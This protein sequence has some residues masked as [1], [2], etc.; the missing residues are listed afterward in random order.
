MEEF[1]VCWLMY[2]VA[3]CV[4]CSKRINSL[5]KWASEE[6]RVGEL[7]SQGQLEDAE[8]CSRSLVESLPSVESPYVLRCRHQMAV[9][10]EDNHKVAEAAEVMASVVAGRKHLLG[11]MQEDTI[12]STNFLAGQFRKLERYEE[13]E[14]LYRDVLKF[15]TLEAGDDDPRTLTALVRN[16]F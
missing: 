3:E 12:D 7:L 10:L 13:A 14:Q 15:R 6:E 16:H 8:A 5:S 4:K 9:I 1:L 11:D 2:P